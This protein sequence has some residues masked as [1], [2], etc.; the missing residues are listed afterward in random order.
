V[1]K[2][3]SSKKTFESGEWEQWGWGHMNELDM[4]SGGPGLLD[5]RFCYPPGPWRI[6]RSTLNFNVQMGLGPLAEGYALILSKR[7]FSCCAE[8]PQ[9]D[10]AEFENLVRTVRQAQINLYGK[11]LMFEHGRSGACL[12]PGSGE[13]LCYHAHLH[14]LPA[15]INLADSISSDFP[16]AIFDTWQEVCS[17]Y[18][19]T[20][21]PYLLA[22]KG[23]G[24]VYAETPDRIRSRYLRRIAAAAL[25]K[26]EL[27]DWVAF[28]SYSVVKAGRDKMAMELN[29]LIKGSVQDGTAASPESRAV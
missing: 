8:L 1:L 12:P 26:P 13:D 6:I 10:I 18:A 4:S 3:T 19:L 17:R 28:P 7:H 11:S 21:R 20:G 14:F 9:S 23:R 29:R 5:C 22:E 24:I 2:L 16:A 25:D 15:A 27:E